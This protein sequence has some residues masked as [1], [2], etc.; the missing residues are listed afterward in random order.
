MEENL[1]SVSEIA[2][3]TDV[4]PS[5]LRAWRNRNGLFPHH[6]I[7]P[8]WTRYTM[9]DA[10]AIAFVAHLTR[11]GLDTQAVINLANRMKPEF[12][13]S[14]GGGDAYYLID[15]SL[16]EA[17]VYDYC[18]IKSLDSRQL[19]KSTGPVMLIVELKVIW[20]DLLL[21]LKEARGMS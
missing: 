12:E 5:T 21:K 2:Q 20:L 7:G 4:A 10:V 8:G 3:I 17:G 18:R 6:D 14:I 15:E 9:A 13:K 16:T 1:I 11:F 19:T